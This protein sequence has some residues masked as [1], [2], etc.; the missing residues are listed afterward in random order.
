MIPGLTEKDIASLE[1]KVK[2]LEEKIATLQYNIDTG[3]VYYPPVH[4]QPYYKENFGYKEG[5]FP[6][7]EK[8]LIREVCLPIFVDITDEQVDYVINCVKKELQ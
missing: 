5:D 7:S 8:N 2:S 1:K 6:T 3:T 4:L